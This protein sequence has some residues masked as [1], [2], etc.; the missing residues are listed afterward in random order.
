[1]NVGF[2]HYVVGA[3][4]LVALAGC[5]RGFLQY[6]ERASWRHQAEVSCLKSGEVKI[7][8]GV[9]QISPIEGPGMC[10]A[11][12]PLKVA[13]LGEASAA[14]GYA[15]ELRPPAAIGNTSTSQMPQWPPSSSR[16]APP[17]QVAPVES[18]PIQ[19]RSMRWVPGPPPVSPEQQDGAPASRPMSISPPGMEPPA[20]DDV[21]DDA[22]VPA[23]RAPPVTPRTQPAYNAPAYEPPPREQPRPLPSL[24][25]ARGP[26]VMPANALATLTPPATL[27]CPIVSALDRWVS[28]GVQPAAMHWFGVQVTE[29]KQISAYSCRGMVGAGTSHIS[30]HAFGNALDIAGFVFADGRR[31]MVK[32]GWHGAPEEQGFL[33]DVQLYACE[34]FTT[35]L[36]PGYNAA[37]YNHIHVDLMRRASGRR[38][39]RPN[40]IPGEV[41]AAKVRSHYASQRGPAY[42]GSIKKPVTIGDMIRNLPEA[43]PGEDGYVADDDDDGVTGSIAQPAAATKKSGGMFDDAIGRVLGRSSSASR[44][45]AARPEDRQSKGF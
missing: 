20:D 38:P 1:M 23:D 17:P 24:G 6:G 8:Y 40:A 25:P 13:A 4:M 32:D 5:G 44:Q 30:E 28:A 3:V 15:G 12:F 26:S 37:H 39:C 34:T 42:T 27:A 7:G 43:L 14:V 41:V 22:V 33:H 31:I 36:A 35:V 21:P 29:I 18:E 45:S 19:G 9:V 10:G 11:D 16:Y 2:R